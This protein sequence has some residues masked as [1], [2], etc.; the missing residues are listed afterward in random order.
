[1]PEKGDIVKMQWLQKMTFLPLRFQLK[2]REEFVLPA[3]KG[4][5]FRGGFGYVFKKSVCAARFVPACKE[6]ILAPSCVYAYVFETVRP[7]N[8]EVMRKYEH[9]PHPFV[10]CP[11]T[12]R[13]RLIRKDDTLDLEMVLIGR[14][15]EYL[16]Y[17]V[18]TVDGLA[19]DG[20]GADKGKCE[21]LSVSSGEKVIFTPDNLHIQVMPPL[22][23]P[24]LSAHHDWQ[25]LTLNFLTPLKLQ[26]QGRIIKKGLT[27]QDIF[28]ALLRRITLLAVFHCGVQHSE[29]DIDFKELIEKAGHIQTI[30]DNTRWFHWS[31]YSTRQKRV[32]PAGGLV[33]DITF[34]GDFAP[35]WPFLL[36]GEYFH[37][38]KN[39]SF[40]LGK[41]LLKDEGFACK[42][43]LFAGNV[44]C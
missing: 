31:R 33:G 24:E 4:A 26:R 8:A 10:L 25:K 35:F 6:C 2:A 11:P 17:F 43:S 42:K 40:G 39:T 3:Y 12:G 1:L 20:L 38:G 13:Q 16:P 5:T 41:Y 30:K 29:I 15:I 36:L 18:L 32:M 9:V 44:E 22:S 23:L 21:L 28:R 34:E 19:R 14:A 37:V 7:D 27:F